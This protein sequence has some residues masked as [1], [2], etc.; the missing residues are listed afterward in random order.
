[1]DD[2]EKENGADDA[3]EPIDPRVL[4]LVAEGIGL[5]DAMLQ[6]NLEDGGTGDVVFV[7]DDGNII[8]DPDPPLTLDEVDERGRR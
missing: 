1:M 3:D 8:P 6:I 4:K 5:E 7:D 2:F